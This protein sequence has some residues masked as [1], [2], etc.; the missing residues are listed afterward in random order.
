MNVTRAPERGAS[1]TRVLEPAFLFVPALLLVPAL[2]QVVCWRGGWS[3][4][5]GTERLW[6]SMRL[7]AWKARV[8]V[9]NGCG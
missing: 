7:T 1:R 2:K 5:V 9:W 6:E 3:A 8:T 4:G